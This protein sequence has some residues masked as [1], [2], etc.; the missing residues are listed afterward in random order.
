M[1]RCNNADRT[2]ISIGC[3][4]LSD[5]LEKI[6]VNLTQRIPKNSN[7]V[8]MSALNLIKEKGG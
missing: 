1:V 7:T 8:S 3:K 6:T 4:E 2:R 5:T